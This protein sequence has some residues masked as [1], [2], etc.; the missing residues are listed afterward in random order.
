MAKYS[1]IAGCGHSY[2][3]Q[4][5]GS[6]AAW[7]S[8]LDQMDSAAGKCNDCYA[9]AKQDWY[10]EREYLIANGCEVK[11]LHFFAA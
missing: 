6:L 1:S 4:V 5:Y 8:R 7:V 9:A 2:E 11:A 3:M 10:A